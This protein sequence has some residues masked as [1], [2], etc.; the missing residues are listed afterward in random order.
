M[1][2]EK[3]RRVW[4]LLSAYGIVFAFLSWIHEVVADDLWWK[5]PL[6][7]VLG[8]VLYRLFVNRV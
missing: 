3:I 2:N 5:G 1:K 8:L 6:A 7:L 4:M